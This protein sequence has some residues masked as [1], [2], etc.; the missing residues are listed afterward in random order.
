M[1]GVA[2]VDDSPGKCKNSPISYIPDSLGLPEID[3]GSLHRFGETAASPRHRETPY[4]LSTG[5]A[6]SKS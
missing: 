1:T 3:E 5:R 2:A 4:L 6:I